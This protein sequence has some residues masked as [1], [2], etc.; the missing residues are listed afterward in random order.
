MRNPGAFARYRFRE[1]L[2]PTMHFRLAYDALRE[3]R[4]ERADVEYVRILH[5]AA[6]TM[7]ATV[8]SA[9]SLLLEA[10]ES[11]DYAEVQDL[12]EPKVPEAP[13][14]TLS[15]QPDLKIY[16]RLLTVSLATAQVATWR[17]ALHDTE[18]AFADAAMTQTGTSPPSYRFQWDVMALAVDDHDLWDDGDA[19][20]VSLLEAINL[21]ATGVPTIDATPQVGETLNAAIAGITDGNGLDS[22]SY[23]YQ[24]IA[25]GPN[26]DGTTGSSLTLTS[27]Q[28]GQTIQVR[29]SFIDDDGF[30]ETATSEA[31][32]AVAAAEQ[33]NNAPTGLPTISGTPQVEQTLTADTSNIDD[34][35]GLTNVSYAYQWLAAGTAISG[36]IGSSYTLTANEQG[37]TIQVRVD[38]EDDAGNSESLTSVATDAVAAKPVPLTATFSNVPDSHSGSG[39]FTFDLAF[40]ENFPLSYRTLRDHAF[41]EDDNGPVTRAQRK[42]QGSNQT[43]TIT[44]EPRA[45]AQS[46]S[47]FPRPPTARPPARSAPTTAACCRIR[48]RSRLPDLNNSPVAATRSH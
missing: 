46:P 26:I 20:T 17:L 24:W 19:F 23:A 6:T 5:L 43:W 8:D 42:V 13:V 48:R 28:E 2:F 18:L 16:D 11:F 36:A 40:S 30:S 31:T 29:V 14:L 1:Q 47:R 15:G 27:S 34:G 37:N 22:V 33:A 4:G 25:G 44:V 21:S 12:A 35:N 9:L 32:D 7:E 41:T 39:E 3:W 10:G 45:T 38:F